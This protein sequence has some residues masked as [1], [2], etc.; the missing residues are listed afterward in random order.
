[1]TT[2]LNKLRR[3]A[4]VPVDLSKVENARGT[5]VTPKRLEKPTSSLSEAAKVPQHRGELSPKTKKNMRTR[6]G[7]AKKALEALELARDELMQLPAIDYMEDIPDVIRQLHKMLHGEDGTGGI[8]HLHRQFEREFNDMEFP[9][10]LENTEPGE[11]GNP[12]EEEIKAKAAKK[13]SVKEGQ[14]FDNVANQKN[15]MVNSVQGIAQDME[16]EGSNTADN[17]AEQEEAE[18]DVDPRVKVAAKGFGKKFATKELE[19]NPFEEEEDSDEEDCAMTMPVVGEAAK[20]K[21][22]KWLEKAEVK[23]EEKEGKKVS[24]TEK[25]KVGEAVGITSRPIFPANKN[26]DWVKPGSDLNKKFAADADL[27][28]NPSAPLATAGDPVNVHT[29]DQD[30]LMYPKT[31]HDEGP[32]Q[33]Q[34]NPYNES[35]KVHV[36]AAIKSALKAEADAAQKNADTFMSRKDLDSKNFYEDMAKAF[37]ELH[38]KLDEGTVYSI[39]EAQILMTSMM[40]I[41]T[42]KIPPDVVKFIA[43]G[44]TVR[45]LKDYLKKVTGNFDEWHIH[46]TK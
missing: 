3:L 27:N 33:I 45:P 35:Q 14:A 38:S 8:H 17:P 4:G 43:A 20:N 37:T 26:K 12:T 29:S 1:M 24:K 18:A 19:K 9:E 13:K 7:C 30:N 25:E 21:K 46:P 28:K 2:D 23:A 10:D 34:T 36:P 15:A 41:F 32:N 22:P 42:N 31:D 5:I 16:G 11:D 39:K 44:G 40:S 6:I